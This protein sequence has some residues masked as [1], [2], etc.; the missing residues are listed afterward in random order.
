MA[1]LANFRDFGPFWAFLPKIG[2]FAHFWRSRRGGFYIN[3]SRRGPV[4][5]SGP[6]NGVFP[7]YPRGGLKSRF[8][9]FWGFPGNPGFLVRD[10]GGVSQPRP[11]DR[12]PA[13]GVDVKPPTPERSPG[14]P[15]LSRALGR[16]ISRIPV[17]GSLPGAL[18]PSQG[19]LRPVPDLHGGVVLHQ[20]LAA[21]PCPRP[22]TPPGD[23]GS[24]PGALA[25][26]RG[27]NP[28]PGEGVPLGV[29]GSR[30][31]KAAH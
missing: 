26:R 2:L 31:Q 27:G 11:G 13:R 6:G 28:R 14:R 4:P 19:P 7:G 21:G 22:G 16:A 10:P 9:G 8:S 23:P 20:P 12:A 15:W 17:P 5:A 18:G 3:P 29:S 1:F 30:R 25:P 24:Q